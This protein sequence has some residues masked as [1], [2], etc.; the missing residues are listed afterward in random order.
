M[1]IVLLG[2]PGSG[3]GTQAAILKDQMGIPHISTGDLLRGAVKAGTELGK[4]AEAIM[5]RGDL[6]SD[7]IMLGIIRS[8]LGEDDAQNGF[9]LDGYPRNLVQAKALDG[10]LEEL[11]F[12]VEEAIQIDVD[13]EGIVERLAK[14]AEL[15]GRAD[16]DADAVRHR[17][18]VYEEQTAPVIDYYGD[19]GKLSQVYGVGSIEEIS[20]R[21]L[22]VLRIAGQERS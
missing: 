14:R 13:H 2:A 5:A 1:R 9:I 16:D 7:E 17:L 4:Q 3:K 21:I 18:N 15:E 10:V 8:R 11:E 22:G 19:Q 12:P 20:A 6:V